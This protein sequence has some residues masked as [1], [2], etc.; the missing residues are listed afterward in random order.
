MPVAGFDQRIIIVTPP[1]PPVPGHEVPNTKKPG[2]STMSI[3]SGTTGATAGSGGVPSPA[4]STPSTPSSPRAD[5]PSTTTAKPAAVTAPKPATTPSPALL[6][7]N[8]VRLGEWRAFW[9]L[10][11]DEQRSLIWLEEHEPGVVAALAAALHNERDLVETVVQ[12]AS[13]ETAAQVLFARTDRESAVELA[14][15]FTPAID[16]GTI[17]GQYGNEEMLSTH[18]SIQTG[19]M[20]A[21]TEIL[22][23]HPDF[24]TSRNVVDRTPF[25]LDPRGYSIGTRINL[26]NVSDVMGSSRLSDTYRRQGTVS[27]D[28]WLEH[29]YAELRRGGE[30]ANEAA[31]ILEKYRLFQGWSCDEVGVQVVLF[32][33]SIGPIQASAAPFRDIILLD[34]DYRDRTGVR[35]QSAVAVLAHELW[36]T[37][38]F[39]L[40]RYSIWGE[41]DAYSLQYQ[42]LGE[43]GFSNPFE[44]MPS[45][46]QDLDINLQGNLPGDTPRDADFLCQMRQALLESDNLVYRYEPLLFVDKV[47]VIAQW[48]PDPG[49]PLRINPV[50][51]QPCTLVDVYLETL[52]QNGTHCVYKL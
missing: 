5:R 32:R 21:L 17:R 24:P 37:E 48:C 20:S 9:A 29:A 22:S 16:W 27:C 33:D 44:Y 15:K 19:G 10:V 36:H 39:G 1:R 41:I 12:H 18:S 7:L 26:V 49:A 3:S 45:G 8:E 51:G 31:D 13:A 30:W 11:E 42:V 43:F 23:R 46:F 50:T 35:F 34:K 40:D 6:D 25:A 47:P 4:P 28:T 38:Q 14:Q 52:D 2:G